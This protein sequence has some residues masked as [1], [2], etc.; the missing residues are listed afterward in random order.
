MEAMENEKPTIAI[1]GG[2]GKEGPGLA[3]RWATAGYRVIIGSRQLE[4][5]QRVAAELNSELGIESITGL[6]NDSAA[7]AAELCVLTVVATAHRA[8]VEG[9]KEALVGKLLI[10]ATARVDFRAPAVPE[11]PSAARIAQNILGGET[12]VV[13]AL[14]NTPAHTLRH[15]LGG[16]IETDVLVFADDLESVDPAIELIQAGGMRAFYAGDL[17][18]AIVAEG[19]T[20]VLIKMNKYYRVKDATIG[21]RGVEKS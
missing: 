5:A 18:D 16:K 8:A 21:V 11:Q 3:M 20:S 15:N 4:K 12:R 7:R 14:Q 13:A 2:T 19:L 17:D 10:D 1:L 9:L 6:D